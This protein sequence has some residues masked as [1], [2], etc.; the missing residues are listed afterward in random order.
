M[1]PLLYVEALVRRA[2]GKRFTNRLPKLSLITETRFHEL[3]HDESKMR[4]PETHS[5]TSERRDYEADEERQEKGK[6]RRPIRKGQE[7]RQRT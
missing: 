2:T 3:G 7:K 4:L 6:E 1:W 5:H